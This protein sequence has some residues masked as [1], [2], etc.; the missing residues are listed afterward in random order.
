MNLAEWLC[1][2]WSLIIG[3]WVIQLSSWERRCCGTYSHWPWQSSY[4]RSNSGERYHDMIWY[5]MKWN[6][7]F[8]LITRSQELLEPPMIRSTVSMETFTCV[9]VA[10]RPIVKMLP[11]MCRT[12]DQ[13]ICGEVPNPWGW[14]KQWLSSMDH[15]EP[16]QSIS[17]IKPSIFL[18]HVVW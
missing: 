2:G 1:N 15:H 13:A 6:E 12:S 11:P 16:F 17:A 5:D 10:V 3:S 7:M 18:L 9:A 4:L 8:V 14:R